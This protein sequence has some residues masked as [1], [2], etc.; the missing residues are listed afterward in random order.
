[1]DTDM[2]GSPVIG[3]TQRCVPSSQRG[4]SVRGSHRYKY[5]VFVSV[6]NLRICQDAGELMRSL[7]LAATR[8]PR[9]LTI[10][11]KDQAGWTT[12]RMG[13]RA[14]ARVAPRTTSRPPAKASP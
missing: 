5:V 12:A 7:I 4:A 10:G 14:T 11:E 13:Q 9:K 6:V 8:L 1:M 2:N 3:D